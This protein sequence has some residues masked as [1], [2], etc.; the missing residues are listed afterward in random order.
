[1]KPIKVLM[2]AVGAPGAPGI[3]KSLR[4]NGEREIEIIG[5][6]MNPNAVG[7]AMVDKYYI[8]PSGRADNFVGSVK[9]ITKAEKID[10]VLPLSTYELWA[11]S[12]SK[13]GFEIPIMVSSPFSIEIANDKGKVYDYL[14]NVGLENAVPQYLLADSL[15][16]F[17]SGVRK[18]GFPDEPVCFKPPIS[19]G[20]RGFRILD[21]TKDKLDLLLNYKPDA[22]YASFEEMISV[23]EKASPFPTLLL[24]EYLPGKEYSVDLL[25][26][27][28]K[29]LIVV[30]RLR[31]ETKGGISF[32][33]T[34]EFNEEL[35]YIA[36]QIAKALNLDYNI[37]IQFRYSTEN[38]PKLLEINPRVSGTIVMNTGAGINLPYLGVKLALGETFEI[39]QVRWGTSMTRYW[40]EIFY[41]S[42]GTPY[43]VTEAKLR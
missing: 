24:C 40:E 39:P 21:N 29:S 16:T 41:E 27:E 5:T 19:K 36:K 18:L 3:I 37:N 43:G 13:N 23:L 42:D 33:G 1:M 32:R 26:R 15:E 31:A 10:V 11:F 30:P 2:T 6:D 38:Q 4:K 17:T 9:E 25:C 7:F 35:I 8:V 28:G 34:I 20:S 14:S 22:T 12:N